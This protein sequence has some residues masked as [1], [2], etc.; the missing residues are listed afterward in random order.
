MMQNEMHYLGL[1]VT[2]R[3]GSVLAE[4]KVE[5]RPSANDLATL[6]GKALCEPLANGPHC[7]RRIHLRGHHQWRELFSQLKELGIDVAV[8]QELPKV[9]EAYRGY[10]RKLR[11]THRIGMVRPTAEQQTIEELFPTI[12]RYVQGYGHIEIGEH[13]MFGFVARAL[14]YGGMV[15]E[16]D[17]PD[18]LAEAM[19]ALEAGLQ[20][21]FEEQGEDLT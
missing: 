2:K 17:R 10:L 18:T 15:F 20:K 11:A 5:G 21:W 1:V 4:T 14:D 19:A 3:G 13:E 6:L 16:D 8:R 9:T 12:A 7:P